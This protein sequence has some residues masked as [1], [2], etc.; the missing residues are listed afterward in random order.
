LDEPIRV[1]TAVFKPGELPGSAPGSGAS[2]PRVTVLE[3]ANNVL[4]PGQAGKTL[5]GRATTG[6]SA[7]AAR[8]EG[9][10]TGYWIQPLGPPDPQYNGELVFSVGYDVAEDAPAGLHTLLFAAVDEK[11]NAGEQASLDVCITSPIPDNLNACDPTIAPPAAVLS[12]AWDTDAD[13][14]LV[15]VTPSGKIVDAKHPTT[16]DP[17]DGTVTPD[18][19]VD[20]IIDRDAN[21][22][23]GG[24]RTR[25]EN[26]V[27]QAKPALG[28][29]LVYANLFSACGADGARFNVTLHLAEPTGEGT[30]QKLVEKIR[31]SGRLLPLDANGGAAVG[32]YVTAFIIN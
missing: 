29:Y 28:T 14:D 22:A 5:S 2:G 32:L 1:T 4:R 23:C 6:A 13:V 9:L 7:V 10:G 18:K 31:A 17:E 8:L 26:A 27:W 30:N 16:K 19:K 25:R 11:G 12:L 20:G 24:D 15:L 3:S 21:A